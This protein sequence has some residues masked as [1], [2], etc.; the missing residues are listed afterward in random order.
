MRRVGV[1]I[2]PFVWEIQTTQAMAPVNV[3]PDRFRT[4]EAAY[5]AGQARLG[6]FLSSTPARRKTA[7]AS[8]ASAP[9]SSVE[10]VWQPDEDD[11]DAVD[12]DMG[13]R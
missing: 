2:A 9:E 8:Q 1:G 10:D 13:V 7:Q 6:E 3:S 4:M 12:L 11:P 5:T